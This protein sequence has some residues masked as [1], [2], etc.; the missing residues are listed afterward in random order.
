MW[1]FTGR[2]RELGPVICLIAFIAA[3]IGSI[4]L[5]VAARLVRRHDLRAR[6]FVSVLLAVIAIA[7]VSERLG[8]GEQVFIPPHSLNRGGALFIAI[9]GMLLGAVGVI[10]SNRARLLRV[11]LLLVASG[12]LFG[13]LTGWL[14]RSAGPGKYGP[15]S[16]AQR[17]LSH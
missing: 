5:I 4:F 12:I 7:T 11:F 10:L 2:Y 17:K 8:Y 14:R 9:V 15:P 6:K 16:V 3:S 13:D 1:L